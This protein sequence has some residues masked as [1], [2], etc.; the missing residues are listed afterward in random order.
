VGLLQ[1]ELQASQT[2]SKLV[3]EKSHIWLLHRKLEVKSSRGTR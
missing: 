1:V 2:M 3:S